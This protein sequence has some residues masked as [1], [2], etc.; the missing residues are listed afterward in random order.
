M[1]AGSGLLAL[2]P[3]HA[4][5]RFYGF[6]IA[7]FCNLYTATPQFTHYHFHKP[8][9]ACRRYFVLPLNKTLLVFLRTVRLDISPLPTPQGELDM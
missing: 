3:I 9:R 7:S 8:L 4:L 1:V 5:P 2:R 6:R